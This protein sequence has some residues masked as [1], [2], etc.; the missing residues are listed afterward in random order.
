MTYSQTSFGS[1]AVTTKAA[2]L[3][4]LNY[5]EYGKYISKKESQVTKKMNK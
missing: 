4:Q 1:Y 2:N 3:L 5:E